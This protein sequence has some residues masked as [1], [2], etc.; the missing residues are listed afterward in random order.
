MKTNRFFNI[1]QRAENDFGYKYDLDDTLQ[2]I[3]NG[4]ENAITEA[5]GCDRIEVCER[6]SHYNHISWNDGKGYQY[7]ADGEFIS[8][9]DSKNAYFRRDENGEFCKVEWYEHNGEDY[10][11]MDTVIDTEGQLVWLVCQ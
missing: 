5:A 7:E 6:G 10:V 2:D 11:L 1:I 9:D 3:L 8:S 4:A